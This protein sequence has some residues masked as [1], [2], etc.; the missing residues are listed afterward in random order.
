M[1]FWS[2]LASIGGSLIP[3]AGAFLGPALGAGV[4]LLENKLGGGSSS[5]SSSGSGLVPTQAQDAIDRSRTNPAVSQAEGY[6]SK[7]LGGDTSSLQELLGPQINTVLSQYDTAAKTA[8]ELS[9][10]GGGRAAQLGEVPFKKIATYGEQLGLART[11]AADKLGSLGTSEANRDSSL[12]NTLI[13]AQTGANALQYQK[14][15]DKNG[16]LGQLGSSFGGLLVD[17]LKKKKGGGSS[18]PALG[19]DGFYL[20]NGTD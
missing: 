14:D 19:S 12:G 13:G 9:P 7:A 10:R 16:M 11:G 15:K 1:G 20:G 6:Y 4:G 8:S 5:G 3:G 17:L 18:G 2:T